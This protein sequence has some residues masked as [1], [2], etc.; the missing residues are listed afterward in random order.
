MNV[1]VVGAG[2][3]GLLLAGELALRGV[4]VTV[5]E[6]RIAPIT[7][8]RAST[9]HA[10][11]MEF[12]DQRGI[13][14]A[15]GTPPC[16]QR[17]HFGGLPLDLGGVDSPYPGQWKVPQPRLEGVLQDWA[18]NLGAK[19]Q[20]G[21][22][23]GSLR[24][25]EDGVT[26][27]DV[28][29]AELGRAAFVV[30]CDG[31]RSTIRQAAGIESTGRDADRELLAADVS[32]INVHNRRFERLP[33][34]MAVA[35]RRPDGVTRL[36]VHRTG[37]SLPDRAGPPSFVEVVTQWKEVTGEDVGAGKVLW[38]HAFRNTSRIARTYR[39]GRVLLAGDAAHQQLPTGGQALNLGLQDA[40]NLGWKLAAQVGG[41]APAG[42]LDSYDV[43]RREAGRRVLQNIDAQAQLLLGSGEVTPVRSVLAELMTYPAVQ[44]RLARMIAG[45]DVRY[46]EPANAE[47]PSAELPNAELLGTRFPP[48]A[49][50][51]A[52]GP[53]S[54]VNRLRSGRGLLLASEP[55]VALAAAWTDRVDIVPLMVDDDSR[56]FLIRP[57]G[58]IAWI[59]GP[60]SPAKLLVSA[61]NLWFGAPNDESSTHSKK[62][63]QRWPGKS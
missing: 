57:D 24:P 44:T 27:L 32:G 25:D 37:A 49:I 19:V 5:L 56:A 41:R 3:T 58:H 30:G 36:M 47:L 63:V 38:L 20:R 21:V 59:G 54:I 43:E 46:G 7:E 55:E 61:L 60:D 14:A 2:P 17:G 42:L 22:E 4:D 18:S 13:L 50:S 31:E 53:V 9:L 33:A 51:D 45:L 40:M 6:R 11:T 15:L 39:A 52:S 62:K 16:E 26:V 29:G 34:G 28:T 48:V 35:A 23:V 12:L 1:I 8:T 10:R